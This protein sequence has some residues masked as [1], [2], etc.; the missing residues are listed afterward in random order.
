MNAFIRRAPH[1]HDM[2]DSG[3]ASTDLSWSEVGQ[4]GMRYARIPAALLGISALYWFVTQPSDALGPIQV[5]EAWIWTLLTNLMLGDG[6]AVLSHHNGWLTQVEFQHPSFP[7]DGGRL[8]LYVS[9]ECAGVYEMLFLGTLIMLTDG[10]SLRQRWRTVL[11][12]S[13]VIYIINIAR[14]LLLYPLALQGC[15]NAPSDPSCFTPMWTFHTAVYEWGFLVLLMGMWFA[16]FLAIGGPNRYQRRLDEPAHGWGIR[17]T[18]EPAQLT[19][20]GVGLVGILASM[21]GWAFNRELVN[22]RGSLQGCDFVEQVTTQCLVDRAA[23]DDAIGPWWSI[24]MLGLATVASVLPQRRLHRM[25][26]E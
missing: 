24:G 10:V 18:W 13:V 19:I 17:R 26:E 14:L 1:G 9:D 20:A 12:A 25:E 8:I 22:L 6:T 16:W 7:T 2:A 15:G 23:Y 11:V 3:P 21:S 4:L 5:T